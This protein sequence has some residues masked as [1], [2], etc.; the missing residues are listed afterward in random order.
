MHDSGS[1]LAKAFASSPTQPAQSLQAEYDQLDNST[2]EQAKKVTMGCDTLDKAWREL[3]P[4][5][6]E[7]QALL[8]QR[9]ADRQ[10]IVEIK[11]P[12]WTKW[13]NDFLT[14]TGLGIRMR[15]VQNHLNKFRGLNKQKTRLSDPPRKLSSQEQ[16]RLLEAAQRGNELIQALESSGDYHPAMQ[17]YKRFMMGPEKLEQMLEAIPSDLGLAATLSLFPP[18]A[19]VRT[20][21][22]PVALNTPAPAMVAKPC[23]A[24][25]KAGNW[26]GLADFV[27][28][29]AGEGITA[30]LGGLDARV[31]AEILQ[32][33]VRKI[34]QTCCPCPAE[35][36]ME[37]KYVRGGTAP[38]RRA[39]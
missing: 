28:A 20:T 8:S 37:L 34:V 10:H 27:C 11:L 15:T 6:N 17:E 14:E 39:A 7:M 21:E 3:L 36:L 35:I 19:A 13:L 23:I 30:A 32:M 22:E 5:L 31:A 1:K 2:R 33:A 38:V 18:A 16:K 9:G 29:T 24:L 25:P 4:K 26:S 12:T